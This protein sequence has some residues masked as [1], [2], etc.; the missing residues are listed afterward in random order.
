MF[1][2]L[3]D[4]RRKR[5]AAPFPSEWTAILE[6]NVAH[7]RM[8]S[9]DERAHLGRLV[10]AFVEEKSWEGCGGL[11]LTDEI[12]VTI[13]ALAC[14]LVLGLDHALYRNV[15]SILV[16]P[17]TVVAPGSRS[18]FAG[19]LAVE[20]PAVPILGQAMARGPVLLVWDAVRHDAIHPEKGHNVVYHEFAHKLDMLDGW[21]DGVPPL[22][23]RERHAHWVEVCTREFRELE[24]RAESGESTLLDAYGSTSLSEFFAVATELFFDRPLSMRAHHA[25]LYAVLQ[26]FYRQDPAERE[27]RLAA[28][29]ASGSESE[30]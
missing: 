8:L 1:G 9:G 14:L 20:R 24:R 13:A 11:V 16:Y 2:W 18:G 21:A 30:G 5:A 17:S 3:A 10:E 22:A 4:H 26:D 12:E 25:E 7:W 19:G 28:E 6:R 27:A 23:G 29:R 15:Q